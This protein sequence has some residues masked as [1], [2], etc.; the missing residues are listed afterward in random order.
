MRLQRLMWQLVVKSKSKTIAAENF[1]STSN[2]GMDATSIGIPNTFWTSKAMDN[3]GSDEMSFY[4][5]LQLC[6][7]GKSREDYK[8]TWYFPF[9]YIFQYTVTSSSVRLWSICGFYVFNTK[10]SRELLSMNLTMTAWA[11]ES[12]WV[13]SHTACN[14]TAR[15]SQ[16][17]LIFC[18][19]LPCSAFS[20]HL[21]LYSSWCWRTED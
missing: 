7:N 16:A 5:S 20:L 11:L 21:M 12:T 3:H 1:I 4:P 15:S 8:H 10:P 9:M 6:P 17:W 2:F 18:G 14:P 13:G 19:E